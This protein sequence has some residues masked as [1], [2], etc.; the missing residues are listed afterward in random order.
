MS[1]IT[2][3]LC[4]LLVC[5]SLVGGQK[6]D[7]PLGRAGTAEPPGA[8]SQP[9]KLKAKAPDSAA[10]LDTVITYTSSFLPG[11]R[12]AT[13]TQKMFAQ[14]W[15]DS[16]AWSLT[17][18]S[19]GQTI[20][21]QSGTSGGDEDLFEVPGV[22]DACGSALACK[23]SWFLNDFLRARTDTLRVEKLSSAGAVAGYEN[24]GYSREEAKRRAEAL[25]AYYQDRPL[26]AV[27]FPCH[28]IA[29]HAFLAYDPDLKRL[30]MV[31]AP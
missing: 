28:P 24:L 7:V 8:M 16:V 25:S 1:N 6:P 14:A 18:T 9:A 20:Y 21:Q 26:V 3:V 27:G 13:I 5:F 11:D 10:A 2:A 31:F 17:V 22:F 19:S 12:K 30:V 4:A 29:G 23:K 15:A